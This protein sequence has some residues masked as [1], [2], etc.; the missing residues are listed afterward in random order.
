M[1]TDTP[2]TGTSP[3]H[4]TKPLHIALIGG[5]L[6]LIG[7]A[8]VLAITNPSQ[9]TYEEFATQAAIDYLGQEVCVK[10]PLAFGLQDQCQSALT[11][12]QRQIRQMIAKGT[13]RQNF[14][15]FSLYKTD[16]A[17]T[18]FLPSYH[19]EAVGVFQRFIIYKAIEQK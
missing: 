13:Q 14:G 18:S 16:L 8:A 11:S 5:G 10:A 3:Q 7:V 12:N 2:A 19:V 1:R 6:A 9:A 15:F 4:Q 17:V